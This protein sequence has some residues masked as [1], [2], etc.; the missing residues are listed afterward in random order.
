MNTQNQPQENSALMFVSRIKA[1][2]R[3]KS[4]REALV[5]GWGLMKDQT[6]SLSSPTVATRKKNANVAN[7]KLRVASL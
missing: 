5:Q 6:A 3:E 1:C 4:T 2:R 7:M